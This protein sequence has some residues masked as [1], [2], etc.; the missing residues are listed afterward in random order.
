MRRYPAL[1]WK[2]VERFDEQC[3]RED[4]G[5]CSGDAMKAVGIDAG[6]VNREVEDSFF[7]RTYTDKETGE[8]RSTQDN[9]LLEQND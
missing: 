3:S 4:L 1:W 5:D 7:V 9:K 8:E 2:F 6:A